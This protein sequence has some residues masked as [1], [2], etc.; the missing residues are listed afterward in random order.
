MKGINKLT[1]IV[2]HDKGL[3]GLMSGLIFSVIGILTVTVTAC[4]WYL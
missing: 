2:S 4:V 1:A 3:L